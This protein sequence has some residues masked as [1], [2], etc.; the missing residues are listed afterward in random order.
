[1]HLPDFT[2]EWRKRKRGGTSQLDPK[3]REEMLTLLRAAKGDLVGILDSLQDR[4][5]YL[6]DHYAVVRDLVKNL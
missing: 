3:I 6:D 2:K 4:G 5:I 1:V